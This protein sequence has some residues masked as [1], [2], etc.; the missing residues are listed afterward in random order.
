MINNTNLY[1]E[2]HGANDSDALV[3]IAGFAQGAWTWTW[4]IEDLSKH[5]RVITFDPR[6]VSRSQIQENTTDSITLRTIADDV[7]ALLEHLNIEKAHVL[8]ASF[9]GFV[10]QEFALS[11]PHKLDKLILACTSFGGRNHVAPSLEVLTAFISHDDLNKSERIRKFMIPAFTPEFVASDFEVVEEVCRLRETNHVPTNVYLQQLQIATTFDA[12][13]RVGEITAET[14]VLS[15]AKDIVVPPQNSQN[16][17]NAIPEAKLEIIEN[18]GHL[19]FIEQAKQFNQTVKD[20]L[21]S[22]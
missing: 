1:Y 19:F 14:L 22:N 13:S 20:F 12:E 5:F 6:G 11:S 17:A 8:G 10:A 2:T 3:L 15:G 16:L 4:Q 18:G 9:G 7:A 21:E